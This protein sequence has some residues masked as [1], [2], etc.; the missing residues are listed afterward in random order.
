MTKRGGAF[1]QYRYLFPALCEKLHLAGRFPELLEAIEASKGRGVADL[2]TRRSRHAVDDASVYAPAARLPELCRRHDF[3]YLTYFVDDE[4]TH[5][6]LVARDG[7]LHVP[8]P[9]MV[10]RE[11]I[12]AAAA[13][14]APASDTLD[15]LV[16]W[17][18]PLLEDGTL[19][20]GGHLCVAP[21]DDLANVPFA[22]L[23]LGGRPLAELFSTSRIHNAFHLDHL[24]RDGFSVRHDAPAVDVA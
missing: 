7:S 22:S 17:L 6:V 5:A 9:I 21:D 11:A 10:T 20:R 13:G 8:E 1:A 4:Y 15:A 12:R 3:A 18:A 23:T 2:L 19:E 14:Q 16:A 24:L